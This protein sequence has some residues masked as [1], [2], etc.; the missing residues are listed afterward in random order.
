MSAPLNLDA[1]LR[2]DPDALRLLRLEARRLLSERAIELYEPYPRQAA[3]HAFGKTYRER[4]LLAS[5]QTGKTFCASAEMSYHLTGLY[6][7]WWQGRV[8][9]D[10]IAAW[11]IGVSSELTRDSCQ[12]LLFGRAA[13]PGTGLVPR[14]L[15]VDTTASRGVS[16]GYDTVSVRHVTGANST[17]GFKSYQQDRAKLQAETLDVVWLDEEPPYDIYS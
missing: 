8:F 14:R 17:I 12:R 16:D 9:N 13:A 2:A 6:P 11:A 15:V 7:P 4:L 10:P 1:A 3:F 5:N